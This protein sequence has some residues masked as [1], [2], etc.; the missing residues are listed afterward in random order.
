MVDKPIPPSNGDYIAAMILGVIMMPFLTVLVITM[1]CVITVRHII[2]WNT[3][4][5]KM[6]EFQKLDDKTSSEHSKSLNG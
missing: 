4:H 2:A 3:Y 1:M 6:E 5:E